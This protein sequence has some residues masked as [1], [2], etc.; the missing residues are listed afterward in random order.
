MQPET[1]DLYRAGLHLLL[2][3]D[4]DAFTMDKLNHAQEALRLYENIFHD[5]APPSQ[6]AI[7]QQQELVE[8][9]KKVLRIVNEEKDQLADKEWSVSSLFGSC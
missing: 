8:K 3:Q 9:A 6:R 4:D 1:G 7:A 2:A 5:E